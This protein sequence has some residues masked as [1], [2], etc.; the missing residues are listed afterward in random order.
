MVQTAINAFGPSAPQSDHAYQTCRG[1]CAG[2]RQAGIAMTLED[3]QKPRS[4]DRE[5]MLG[6]KVLTRYA[7]PLHAGE[8]EARYN[9]TF[10]TVANAFRFQGVPSEITELPWQMLCFCPSIL[11]NFVVNLFSGE[12]AGFSAPGDMANSGGKSGRRTL[13]PFAGSTP[14]TFTVFGRSSSQGRFLDLERHRGGTDA[15]RYSGKVNEHKI[16]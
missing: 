9:T 5:F 15:S 6:P 13:D 8:L 14:K 2:Q 12:F 10:P 1:L 3:S 4:I 11:T 16:F 7:C